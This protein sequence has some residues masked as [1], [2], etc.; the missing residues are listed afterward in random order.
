MAAVLLM[1]LPLLSGGIGRGGRY[2]ILQPY[3][4]MEAFDV[5]A[6]SDVPDLLVLPSVPVGP[7][8]K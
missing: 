5:D 4:R 7:E 2:H 8:R 6:A 1:E 3:S